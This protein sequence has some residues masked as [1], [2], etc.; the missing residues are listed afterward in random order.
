VEP[1]A[2]T[3]QLEFAQL[4]QL[5]DR[6]WGK[7]LRAADSQVGLLALAGAPTELVERLLRQLPPRD[8]AALQRKMESLGPV[9]L[10]EIEY[11]QQLLARIAAQLA[12]QGE[13]RLP[14]QR[15]F[16]TAA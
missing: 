11:A 13:I 9:R 15:S 3:P 1:A 12:E 14:R 16:A 4:C 2:R 5:E 10:R 7:I 8:A 6:A